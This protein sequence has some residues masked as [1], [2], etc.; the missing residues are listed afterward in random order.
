[1]SRLKPLIRWTPSL[2]DRLSKNYDRMA[3]W[4]FPIGDRGR[5]KVVSDLKPGRI[6]DVACGTG[7][8]LLKAHRAD[9]HCIGI[10]TSQGML[11][12]TRKKIPEA[13]IVQA[14]FYAL[15]FAEGKFDYVV[16]TNAVSGADID[17]RK[18]L[19]EMWRV[20][21]G[22]GELRIGDYGKSDRKGVF[23]QLL[24][25][26]GILIGDYP[27]DYNGL[28]NEMGYEARVENLGWGGMYQ[29][30]RLAKKQGMG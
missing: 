11:L 14:S 19:G 27:H 4:F 30:I 20:C 26:V 2:Y 22:G 23:I 24:E 10:D 21:T 7:T 5:E 16:E 25:I 28:F 1:M 17:P 12:E 8:L 15:P 13:D 9:L 3:S 29:Y 6:L 18:V